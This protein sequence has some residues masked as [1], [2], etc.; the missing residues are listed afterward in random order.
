[1]W[2]QVGERIPGPIAV[3]DRKGRIVATNDAFRRLVTCWSS[4]DG[5]SVERI[6]L[7]CHRLDL[8]PGLCALICRLN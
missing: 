2:E 4:A 8:D 7:D 1:L 3:I 6:R 5:S